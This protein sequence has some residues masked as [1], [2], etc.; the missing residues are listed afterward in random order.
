MGLFTQQCSF[1]MFVLIPVK[2]RVVKIRGRDK[3]R[4]WSGRVDSVFRGFV[5]LFTFGITVSGEDGDLKS[6]L[7]KQETCLLTDSHT[8]MWNNKNNK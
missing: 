2:G 4:V 6:Q 5:L 8:W 3:D 7:P 1:K